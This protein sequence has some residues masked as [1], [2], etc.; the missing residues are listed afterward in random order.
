MSNSP[1]STAVLRFTLEVSA[2]GIEIVRDGPVSDALDI[3]EETQALENRL[4]NQLLQAQ[5]N[6]TCQ[7][8]R[9]K[10]HETVRLDFAFAIAVL[11]SA[12]LATRPEVNLSAV[13]I[14][15]LAIAT[16]GAMAV[17]SRQSN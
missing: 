3:T 1:K 6:E 12:W 17:V 10:A 7:K 5:I 4:K 15:I 2:A 8:T 16:K 14:A 13:A 11:A 9:S